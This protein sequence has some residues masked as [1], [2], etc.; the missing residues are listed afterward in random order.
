MLALTAAGV[1]WT[2]PVTHRAPLGEQVA[3]VLPDGSEVT[4][5]SGAEL[6]HDRRFEAR[7]VRSW[8]RHFSTCRRKKRRSW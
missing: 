8:A 4:L 6:S 5:A 2:L 1:W 3:V 7:D